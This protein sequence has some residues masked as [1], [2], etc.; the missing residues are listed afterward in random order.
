VGRSDAAPDEL[1]AGKIVDVPLTSLCAK[2][3]RSS[4]GVFRRSVPRLVELRMG[5]V[6]ML[7]GK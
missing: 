2:S 1:K 5:L 6:G 4:Q 3:G 7:D